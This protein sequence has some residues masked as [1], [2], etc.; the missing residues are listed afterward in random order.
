MEETLQVAD[1][2]HIDA[3]ILYASFA[4]LREALL[5]STGDPHTSGACVTFLSSRHWDAPD[6][7]PVS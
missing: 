6:P 2:E 7:D 1:A 4:A 3:T 5:Q